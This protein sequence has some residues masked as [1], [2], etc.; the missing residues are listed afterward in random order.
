[1]NARINSSRSS[2]THLRFQQN[3]EEWFLYH[4]LYREARSTWP[5]I[6]FNVFA[7]WLKRRPD[8]VVGD[9][10]CGEAEL[11]RLI[12]NK[13]YSFDH[14]AVN[15]SVIVCDISATGLAEHT[16]DVAVFSLSLMGINYPDY[17]R[18]AHRLVR[19]GGWLKVAE[20]ATP[21]KE[22]N[23]E[24]LLSAIASSG[25]AIVGQPTYRDRFIYLDAIKS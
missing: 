1:M 4:T 13:V 10:G 6:P 25:F 8:W 2:T 3:P 15:E 12:P 14:V 16:L 11:A 22:R 17:L 21:W 18:E 5:E 23:L 9:F 7:E 19:Y 24:E 20:P